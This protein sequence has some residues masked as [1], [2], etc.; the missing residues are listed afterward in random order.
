MIIPTIRPRQLHCIAWSQERLLHE[1]SIKLGYSINNTIFKCYRSALNSYLNFVKIHEFV[2]ASTADML[3]YIA[4]MSHQINSK[5][6]FSYLLGICNQLKIYFPKIHAAKNSLLV[7]KTLSGSKKRFSSPT[8][9][10]SVLTQDDILYVIK[11]FSAN[12]SYDDILF[13]AMLTTS[14]FALLQLGEMAILDDLKL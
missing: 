9:Q 5:S 3:L 2:T 14:F 11:N 12:S 13:L 8:K 7:K 6:I 1:C 4:Y 10:K